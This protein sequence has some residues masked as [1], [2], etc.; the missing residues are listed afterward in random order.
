MLTNTIGNLIHYDGEISLISRNTGLGTPPQPEDFLSP[1]IIIWSPFEEHGLE[2]TTKCPCCQKYLQYHKKCWADGTQ[3]YQPRILHSFDHTVL[4]VSRVYCCFSSQTLLAHDE[5]LLQILTKSIDIPFVLLHK[6]G[7]TK[8]FINEVVALCNNGM[9]FFKIEAM[10]IEEHWNYHCVKEQKFWQVLEEYQSQYPLEEIPTVNFPK[11]KTDG[12]PSN[13]AIAQCFLKDFMEKEWHCIS[14]MAQ[15]TSDI[16]ISCDHTFKVASNIGYLRED[17]KWVRQYTA[18]FLVMNNEGKVI[19]WQFTNGTSFSY[20]QKLLTN[21]KQRFERQGATI[22]KIT[23]DNCCQWRNKLQ[24]IFGNG[25]TVCLDVFHAV[26]RISRALP[27]KHKLFHQCIDDLRFVFRAGGDIGIKRCK[28]TPLP[29]EMLSNMENFIKKWENVNYLGKLLL[30]NEALNEI[31]KLKVH[32]MKGCLSNIEVGCGT[33]RNEAL[34]KHM[35]SFFHQSRISILLAYAL[36][37]VLIYSHNSVQGS[38][39]K[40]II[41]PISTA[42]SEEVKGTFLSSSSSSIVSNSR[43]HF[44]IMPK[45]LAFLQETN[46][47]LFYDKFL[48][49]CD[50]TSTC[51]LDSLTLLLS[52]SVQQCMVASKMKD[53]KQLQMYSVMQK[54][55]EKVKTLPKDTSPITN[56]YLCN[57]LESNNL[58]LVPVEGDG[59]CCF[60]AVGKGLQHILLENI[61]DKSS[62]VEHINFLGLQISDLQQTSLQLRKLTVDE[63]SGCNKGF[64]ENFLTSSQCIDDAARKFSEPG[65]YEND[66]GD[67]MILALCNV[68]R[69]PI[70]IFSIIPTNQLFLYCLGRLSLISCFL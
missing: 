68:L 37:T 41:K 22:Q 9:N 43:E 5:R 31:E 54:G 7:Y 27:K 66:L 10:C 36:M 61:T 60:T 56:Q 63:W 34:H 25:I 52:R 8:D 65:Y 64:Y 12:I 55:I 70:I 40:Q 46:N 2:K 6:T 69:V 18:L 11:F 35:N 21:L 14:E 45:D 59:N 29:S 44:G 17:D 26:Q 13:D 49:E 48:G 47:R 50:E 24:D 33:N 15:L 67:L 32:I 3:S 51:D 57:L 28:A 38:K 30:N 20:I 16:W 42:I 23:I 1:P 39:A 4:L 19:S 53:C 62:F 58:E